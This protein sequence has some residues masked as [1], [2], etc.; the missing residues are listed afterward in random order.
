MA[1]PGGAAPWAMRRC[2]D[3]GQLRPQAGMD[4]DEVTIGRRYYRSGESE[5]TINGQ[6]VPL[7]GRVRAAAG[8]RPWPRWLR[9]CGQGRIAEIVGAKSSERR[10]ILR[11]PAA[12]P[13]TA[14][15]KT[16]PSAAWPRPREPGTPAGYSGRAGKAGRPPETRQRK[17][18]A[19]PGTSG[20]RKSLEVTLWVDAIRRANRIFPASGTT[21]SA[22][23]AAGRGTDY[24]RLSRTPGVGRV[25][26]K[27]QR[28]AG[29][30]PGRGGGMCCR[31]SRPTPMIRAI[32]RGER[33]QREPVGWPF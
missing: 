11:K 16:R 8:Y 9:H 12:L 7:K 26:R 22:N 15:A 2:A 19:V 25:R 24:D 14:T 30:G 23:E 10:E 31:W 20:A 21:R 13:N 18:G 33:R 29:T 17:G 3:D 6:S 1:A 32:H 28:P 27:E 4:A 5:Y